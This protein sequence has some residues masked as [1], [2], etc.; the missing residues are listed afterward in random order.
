MI[1][2]GDKAKRMPL[3]RSI[4]ISLGIMAS[5]LGLILLGVYAMQDRL[6]YPR[7]PAA[8]APSGWR[9]V[10]LGG[11]AMGWWI[12]PAPGARTIVFF[13]GN[14]VTVGGIV[15]ATKAFRALGYGV[16]APEYPGYAG[17]R[18]APGETSIDAVA[19]R[20]MEWLPRNGI[21]AADTVVYGNSIGSGPAIHAA[22]RPHF[23]LVVVSGIASME[24]VV[25]YHYG[26]IAPLVRDKWRNADAIAKVA[27]YKIV[28]HGASD[29]VVPLSQ[30]Q[31]IARRAGAPL[32][33]VPGGHEIAFD[34]D[35][36][37]ALEVSIRNSAKLGR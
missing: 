13:H 36:Q 2:T 27:G 32:I 33:T 9:M 29:D 19:D 17:T 4:P 26:A 16:L 30:G 11:E 34:E 31:E 25:R 1:N 14:A 20:A 5:G 10:D 35:F 21:A 15:Q 7:T 12:P 8:A 3:S 24:G 22:A 37:Q 28:V 6:I 23:A 18:G